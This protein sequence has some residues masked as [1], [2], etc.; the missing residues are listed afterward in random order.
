MFCCAIEQPF[1][2][3]TNPSG[4]GS[5]VSFILRTYK[6]IVPPPVLPP[7]PQKLPD[8]ATHAAASVTFT[9]ITVVVSTTTFQLINVLSQ[10][11][12]VYLIVT[13][14]QL[15]SLFQEAYELVDL[16]FSEL[17]CKRIYRE[18]YTWNLTMYP[19]F[20][21]DSNNGLSLDPTKKYAASAPLQ[22]QTVQYRTHLLDSTTPSTRLLQTGSNRE[23]GKEVAT[24][25]KTRELQPIFA[26]R[27]AA[28]RKGRAGGMHDAIEM[29][30]EGGLQGLESGQGVRGGDIARNDGAT[31]KRDSKAAFDVSL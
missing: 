30:G 3:I 6:L 17:S 11:C 31:V 16:S 10:A 7:N 21:S 19:P 24:K 2:V 9:L 28:L 5:N 13:G 20:V 15:P 22:Q 29:R 25:K 1:V 26:A 27:R 18:E 12:L 8:D 4:H 14:C 23:A